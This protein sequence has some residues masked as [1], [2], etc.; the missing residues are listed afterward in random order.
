MVDNTVQL[1]MFAIVGSIGAFFVAGL[2]TLLRNNCA[3]LVYCCGKNVAKL[4]PVETLFLFCVLP[5]VT[6]VTFYQ[7]NH[8]KFARVICS[9]VQDV[10][11][12]NPWLVDRLHWSNQ[13]CKEG[14]LVLV[15]NN[16]VGKIDEKVL[17]DHFQ[18]STKYDTNNS[19]ANLPHLNLHAPLASL[20]EAVKPFV[21]RLGFF[22]VRDPQQNPLF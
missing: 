15:Y 13:P 14:I 9:Q 10:L 20:A 19:T 17:E 11:R 2:W 3:P 21:V 18:Y 4:L 6:T 12:A 1:Y 5:S 22:C 8:N 7:G 16:N